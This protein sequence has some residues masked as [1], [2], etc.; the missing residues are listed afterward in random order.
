[1]LLNPKNLPVQ[2]MAMSIWNGSKRRSKLEIHY[3]HLCNK[4]AAACAETAAYTTIW[5]QQKVFRAVQQGSMFLEVQ[6]S[7]EFSTGHKIEKSLCYFTT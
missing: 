4:E 5:K 3:S 2:A 1:M 7:R 6:F